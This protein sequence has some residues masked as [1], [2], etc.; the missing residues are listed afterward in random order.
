MGQLDMSYALLQGVK[1]YAAKCQAPHLTK[2]GLI[3]FL[4]HRPDKNI[5]P[6]KLL[7]LY[8]HTIFIQGNLF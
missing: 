5:L 4:S 6:N 8:K 7:I 3:D 1:V 2:A